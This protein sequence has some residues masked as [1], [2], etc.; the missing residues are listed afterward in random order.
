M[1]Q[2]KRNKLELLEQVFTKRK[3]LKLEDLFEVIGSKSQRTI[4]R[5]VKELK[6]LTS[7]THNGQ[8][9]TLEKIA[10]FN[11]H[12]LWHFDD[13]GFSKHGGLCDTIIFFVEH[14]EAGMTS[15]EL[16]DEAHTV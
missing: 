9:Y 4:Y 7:Y 10:R 15:R 12:G 5:Y 2:T 16:Q 1:N 3:V 8:Y 13:I 6:H 11:E 14:S